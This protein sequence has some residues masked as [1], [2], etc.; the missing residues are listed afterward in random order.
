[1]LTGLFPKH[2]RT[3]ERDD[4]LPVDLVTLAERLKEEGYETAAFIGNGNLVR[5]FGFDQGFDTFRDLSD[6]LEEP[7]LLSYLSDHINESVFEY[8]ERHAKKGR[9]APVF[10]VVWTIDPHF[11]YAPRESVAD[12]FGIERFEP[13][14]TLNNRLFRRIRKKRV[15]LSESQI[16]YMVTR[17][18]QEIF[19]NDISFGAFVDK[20][21]A[22]GL[23]GD[24]VTIFTAD[25]GEEFFDHGFVGH[26]MTLYGEQ[27]EIPLIIKGPGFGRGERS[28]QQVQHIDLYPTLMEI[29]GS[30]GPDIVDGISILSNQQGRRDLFFEQR[31]DNVDI[32]AM[33]GRDRKLVFNKRIDRPLA[34][35]ELPTFEVFIRGDS[36]EQNDLGVT[37]F[38]DRMQVDRLLTYLKQRNFDV[39]P[40]KATVSEPLNQRLK[41][42]GYAR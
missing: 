14:D 21:K 7:E 12:M 25:H 41:A 24:A 23:F 13:V 18:D 29:V 33:L 28:E 26:G 20:L 6:N 3:L 22:M 15:S 5:T 40:Q 4:K 16:E 37:D 2:H 17:Y 1:M 27:V 9:R 30:D 8:L 35:E 36:L 19:F 11:P 32:A 38:T 34:T 42:L 31:L 10:V 39:E